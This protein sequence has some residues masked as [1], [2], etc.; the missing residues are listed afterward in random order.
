MPGNRDLTIKTTAGVFA[1]KGLYY[2]RRK[3]VEAVA[4]GKRNRTFV[5]VES[6]HNPHMPK[7]AEAAAGILK[8]EALISG[9]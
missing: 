8:L 5:P 3:D 6:P 4:S 7:P 9:S 2:N 1:A